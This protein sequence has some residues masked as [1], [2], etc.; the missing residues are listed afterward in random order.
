ML[1]FANIGFFL[2]VTSFVTGI[3]FDRFLGMVFLGGLAMLASR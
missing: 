2:Y 1:S 3:E